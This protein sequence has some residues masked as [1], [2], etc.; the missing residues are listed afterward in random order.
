MR[1]AIYSQY[2][3]SQGGMQT[4][5]FELANAL[6]KKNEVFIISTKKGKVDPISFPLD[7]K[8]RVVELK[9]SKIR[10]LGIL[11]DSYNLRK[12]LK[13]INPH[14]LHF[15]TTLNIKMLIESLY[16]KICPFIFTI[17]DP[18]IN[19]GRDNLLK[20]ILNKLITIIGDTFIVH[21]EKLKKDL[22]FDM[23]I[24]EQSVHVIPHG[25][26]NLF[27]DKELNILEE[28]ETILFFGHIEKYKGIKYLFEAYKILFKMY[29]NIKIIIAGRGDEIEKYRNI[30]DSNPNFEIHNKFIKNSSV[31]SFFKRA[32]VVVLP[33]TAASQSGILSL[34]FSFGK[35]VVASDVGSIGEVL[36]HGYNGLL[37]P[38][39]DSA[40]LSKA[41]SSL[42]EDKEYAQ[43]IGKNAKRTSQTTLSWKNISLETQLVYINNHE[44]N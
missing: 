38:P 34:A 10:F 9:E 25:N 37:V 21:G 30:Y 42:F 16:L 28:K 19:P 1:I 14:V 29:P 2:I 5:T 23:S 26:L 44:L 36:K 3:S 7:S 31:A 35:S 43:E 13:K 39:K 40:A 15:Q 24:P 8:V 6:A 32:S 22:I 41:I 17:H 27:K 11:L 4:Y 12:A 20:K 33:Y 18:R